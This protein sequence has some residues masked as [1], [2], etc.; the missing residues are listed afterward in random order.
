MIHVYIVIN[1]LILHFID[2]T[3]NATH[4]PTFIFILKGLSFE[5]LFHVK[6][7]DTD[8]SL[9]PWEFG[10]ISV[11]LLATMTVGRPWTAELGTGKNT[12]LNHKLVCIYIY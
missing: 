1:I 12:K 11:F 2:T 9:K 10:E 6:D 5:W 4:V 3:L 8:C 7:E